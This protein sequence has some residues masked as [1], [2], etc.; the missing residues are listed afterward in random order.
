MVELSGQHF[1]MLRINEI[2]P[3][4]VAPL[5]EVKAEVR[6]QVQASAEAAALSNI[7]QTAEQV[8]KTVN[9]L[10]RQQFCSG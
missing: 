10:K 6:A 9:L 2:T 3:P 1:V 8:I 4:Q 5:A 7:A